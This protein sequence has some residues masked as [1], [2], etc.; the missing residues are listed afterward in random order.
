MRIVKYSLLC[1]ALALTAACS[2]SG[3]SKASAPTTTTAP[4]PPITKASYIARANAICTTMN[5]KTNAVADPGNDP[6][7]AA[8]ALARVNS[9]IG[10]G[11][12][13]L[14]ALPVPAG[15]GAQLDAIYA[16]VD[17]LRQGLDTYI[18]ALR[19]H[20]KTAASAASTRVDALGNA[21]NTASNQY[22]LTVCG[23]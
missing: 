23:S 14:R 19:A 4:A 2:S 10:S 17:A 11:L 3:S 6:D 8:D 7:K 9:Y 15:E 20:H 22:G 1:V 18:A 16:K 13:Q 21:A 5:R 12:A